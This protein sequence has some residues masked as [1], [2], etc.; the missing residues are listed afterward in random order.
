MKTVHELGLPEKERVLAWV[1]YLLVRLRCSHWSVQLAEE[2]FKPGP[3]EDESSAQIHTH[4]ENLI[5]MLQLGCKWADYSE[6]ER[7]HTLVH[8]VLHLVGKEQDRIVNAWLAQLGEDAGFAMVQH[9]EAYERFIDQLAFVIAPT[10]PAYPD[11]PL[12]AASDMRV[13][14]E[15]MLW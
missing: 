9:S 14:E 15:G 12:T 1:R 3:D 11:L 10:L 4:N 7:R 8:E 13:A 5:A 6:G 2:L